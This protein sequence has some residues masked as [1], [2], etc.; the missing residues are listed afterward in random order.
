MFQNKKIVVWALA[1][2]LVAFAPKGVSAASCTSSYLTCLNDAY[3]FDGGVAGTMGDIEC[4]AGWVG[5]TVSKL[6]FW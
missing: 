3:A 2:A 1:L 5:C 6:K 4:G